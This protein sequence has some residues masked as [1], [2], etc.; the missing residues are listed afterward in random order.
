[1]EAEIYAPTLLWLETDA[2]RSFPSTLKE[3]VH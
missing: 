1:M 2:L 3:V